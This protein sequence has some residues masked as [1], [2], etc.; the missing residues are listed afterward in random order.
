M[1]AQRRAVEDLAE[2]LEPATAALPEE[3]VRLLE[4]ELK[5]FD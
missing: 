2:R 4:D 5:N 1:W 3:K